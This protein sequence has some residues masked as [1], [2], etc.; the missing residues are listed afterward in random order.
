MFIYKIILEVTV[1]QTTVL[2]YFINPRLT[3]IKLGSNIQIH[4]TNSHFNK[5]IKKNLQISVIVNKQVA[6]ENGGRQRFIPVNID[7][8]KQQEKWQW[9][10]RTTISSFHPQHDRRE[11]FK[12]YSSDIIDQS[13]CTYS[14]I[15]MDA[16][17]KKIFR[18][19]TQESRW[20]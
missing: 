6:D 4:K 10:Q 15:W 17:E 7:I 14:E 2:I 16:S 5:Q 3:I 1:D 19:V 8:D 12:V 11:G 20:R 13:L 18:A 9:W